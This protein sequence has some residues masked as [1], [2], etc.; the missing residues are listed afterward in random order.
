MKRLKFFLYTILISLVCVSLAKLLVY[1]LFSREFSANLESVAFKANSNGGLTQFMLGDE[2]SLSLWSWKKDATA[3][4]RLLGKNVEI[5]AF[6]EI[7]LKVKLDGV[8]IIDNSTKLSDLESEFI[9]IAACIM[10]IILI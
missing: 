4:E 7:L 1:E 6:G 10:A 9:G 2:T 8:N 5:T 3:L